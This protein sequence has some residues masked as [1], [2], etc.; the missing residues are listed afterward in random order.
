MWGAIIGLFLLI[1]FVSLTLGVIVCK[2]LWT[3]PAKG[4]K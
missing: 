3:P 4:V 1:W 2:L